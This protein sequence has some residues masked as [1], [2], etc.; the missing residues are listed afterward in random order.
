M[1]TS[2]ASRRTSQSHQRLV[3]LC[4]SALLVFAVLFGA[5][6]ATGAQAAVSYNDQETAFVNLLNNYRVANGLSPLLVSDMISQACDR[7][8]SDMAKYKFFDHYS[9]KSDWFPA[10]ASPWDR[11]AAS[12]YTY[13]T[14]K[15]EN[16]AAGQ[17]TAAQVFAAWKASSGHNANMLNSAYKV[18]GVSFYQF[19]GSPY[20]SYWTTDFGGYVDPTAHT[21]GGAAP[22]PPPP[23]PTVIRYQQTDGHLVWTPSYKTWTTG[24]LP[25]YSGGSI[26]FINKT[27]SVTAS[28]NGTSL[29]WI[30]KIS[31]VYG[32]AKVT[33][34]KQTPVYVDL[35]SATT[36]YQQKVWNT[37]TLAPGTHTVKIEW[38]P[39]RNAASSGTNVNVDAFDVIGTL[40]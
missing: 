35:Y 8:N 1:S 30:A 40:N 36:Y 33:L 34:D 37:G 31:S 24:S 26:K 3:G 23:S 11:M 32:R 15:G 5:V 16:I 4:I 25:N 18:L 19:A 21:I 14:S 38:T 13:N 20:T 7:H 9:A 10:N 17:S 39:T 22:S 29:T 27:G 28:F 12:G 2:I 6:F